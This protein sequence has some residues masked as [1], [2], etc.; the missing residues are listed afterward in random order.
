[1]IILGPVRRVD[2]L[3]VLC[4]RWFSEGIRFVETDQFLDGAD[5][6]KAETNQEVA[7]VRTM[8]LLS[9]QIERVRKNQYEQCS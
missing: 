6:E 5:E 8:P 9:S 7:R 4:F 2:E 1:M 3:F